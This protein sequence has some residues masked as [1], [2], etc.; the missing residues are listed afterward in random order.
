MN[1]EKKVRCSC[2]NER[3]R[4]IIDFFNFMVSTVIV[5]KYDF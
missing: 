2:R 3:D 4:N 1:S 5:G